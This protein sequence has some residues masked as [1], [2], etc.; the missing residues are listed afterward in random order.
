[1]F[2]DTSGY[3]NAI[4]GFAAGAAQKSGYQNTYV[5]SE[6]GRYCD[7]GYNNVFIGYQAEL[8]SKANN[9]VFLG[10][11]AG[12]DMDSDHTLAIENTT[13]TTPL[14]VGGF[15]DD[16]VGINRT[17]ANMNSGATF[18]VG[19]NASKSTSGSWSANSDKRLK[20]QIAYMDSE[21]MLHKILQLKGAT[22]EWNDTVTG[23]P[24]PEGIQYSF[25]AQDIEK[26]WPSKIT[27]DGQ[28]YL[29]TAYGDYDP[30]FVESVR[31]LNNKIEE[32]QFYVKKLENDN[33][34]LKVDASEIDAQ[35]EQKI[36][37]L[38]DRLDE[39]EVFI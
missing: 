1:M 38:G 35:K 14:I 18:Q 4:I 31:A 17:R 32:L 9:S 5:G 28:G 3:D 34:K 10:K 21:E 23:T 24:R 13:S 22:Y 29:M 6:A 30:M 8:N 20:T 11:K 19:G 15:E 25:I 36:E 27:K 37:K 39:L 26:V 12:I 33:E 2:N 16:R 7:D